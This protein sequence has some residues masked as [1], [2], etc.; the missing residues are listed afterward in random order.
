[1]NKRVRKSGVALRSLEGAR[2]ATVSERSAAATGAEV[3]V[4]TPPLNR[5]LAPAPRV[6]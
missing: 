4:A 5:S 6:C 2:S 3:S 1:M